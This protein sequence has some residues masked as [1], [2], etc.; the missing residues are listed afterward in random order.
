MT[1]FTYPCKATLKKDRKLVFNTNSSLPSGP[2]LRHESSITTTDINYFLIAQN[3]VNETASEK[4]YRGLY[5]CICMCTYFTI[6]PF[7]GLIPV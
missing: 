1:F 5:A 7:A 4:T 2:V 3:T 6:F